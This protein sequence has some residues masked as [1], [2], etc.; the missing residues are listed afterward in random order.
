MKSIEKCS[1]LEGTLRSKEEE[2]EVSKGVEAECSD[3]QAQ[4]VELRRQLE[5]CQ[6]Q[7]AGL[8][9]EDAEKQNELE[10]TASF[11]LDVRGNWRCLS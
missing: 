11:R 4:V 10:K 9:G 6:L 1:V 7:L 8:G 3:L 5:E 2:L